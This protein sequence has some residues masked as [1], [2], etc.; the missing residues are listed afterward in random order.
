MTKR[1]TND[2]ANAIL[3]RLVDEGH[4]IHHGGH[5][6]QNIPLSYSRSRKPNGD[7]YA[8]DDDDDEAWKALGR[9]LYH[10]G[11]EEVA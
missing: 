4:L 5:P 6:D 2:K 3:Q 8:P 10:P 1:L 11:D 9:S 7:L